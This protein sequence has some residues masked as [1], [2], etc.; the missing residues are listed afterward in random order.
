MYDN[1]AALKV[2]SMVLLIFACIPPGR[3]VEPPYYIV[4][5]FLAPIVGFILALLLPPAVGIVLAIIIIVVQF[6]RAE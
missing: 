3:K 6:I 5:N 1:Y 4:L 2:V